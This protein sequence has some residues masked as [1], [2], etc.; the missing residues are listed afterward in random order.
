MLCSSLRIWSLSWTRGKRLNKPAYFR[1][2][3]I[4][5]KK[6]EGAVDFNSDGKK[7]LRVR[8]AGL[9]GTG[10]EVYLVF[11]AGRKR[12]WAIELDVTKR[13][14]HWKHI[15]SRKDANDWIGSLGKE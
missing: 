15:E 9:Q 11:K 5:M 12:W 14:A 4:Q 8:R 1:P 3:R 7:K 2:G 10:A 6:G 13:T